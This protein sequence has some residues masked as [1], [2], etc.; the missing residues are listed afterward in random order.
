MQNTPLPGLGGHFLKIFLEIFRHENGDRA[1]KLRRKKTALISVPAVNIEEKRHGEF[2]LHAPPVSDPLR[3]QIHHQGGQDREL[4]HLRRL[5]AEPFT[6]QASA[7]NFRESMQKERKIWLSLYR[8]AAVS[9]LFRMMAED[10]RIHERKPE[11]AD[12]FSILYGAPF[13]N[14]FR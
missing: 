8:K 13:S 2:C 5:A 4:H 12:I 6:G 11:R 9:L 7:G 10:C 14:G 3:N 1:G